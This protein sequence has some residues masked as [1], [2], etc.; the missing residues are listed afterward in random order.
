[1]CEEAQWTLGC[2]EN[3]VSTQLAPRE[4]HGPGTMQISLHIH[5]F[6][7]AT[8]PHK[9]PS[10]QP[11]GVNYARELVTLASPDCR[12]LEGSLCLTQSKG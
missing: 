12:D 1:M 3:D 11:L 5:F 6:R 9:P 8:S 7:S 10:H 4:H 2:P